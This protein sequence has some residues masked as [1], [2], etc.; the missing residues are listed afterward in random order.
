MV[1]EIEAKTPYKVV[2]REKA[3]TI[4]EVRLVDERKW[5]IAEDAYD[6]ARD[7]STELRAQISG[8]TVRGNS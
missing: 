3:D 8:L 4:L 7:V 6:Q 1:K 2:G 5:V